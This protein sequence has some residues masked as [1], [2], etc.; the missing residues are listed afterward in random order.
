MADLVLVNGLPGSGKTTLATALARILPAPLIAKD[1]IKEAVADAVAGIPGPA[2]G[3]AASEMMWTL[4]GAVSGTVVLESWWYR[5]RDLSFVEAGLR[6]CGAVRVVEIWCDVPADVAAA[7]DA[8]RRR[9]PVHRPSGAWPGA[10]PLGVGPVIVV[11]TTGPVDLTDVAARI[12]AP[13]P[14]AGR[15]A[16]I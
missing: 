5:P 14:I 10:V 6:R 7:R 1:A 13:P 4:A 9:H 3:M 8:A 2:L 16:S 11:D 15:P 12:A